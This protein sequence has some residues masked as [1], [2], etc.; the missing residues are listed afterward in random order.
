M[1]HLSFQACI[2]SGVV[3]TACGTA[4]DNV[5]LAPNRLLKHR[6]NKHPT[7]ELDARNELNRVKDIFRNAAKCL[8]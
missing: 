4:L 7:M 5:Q 6:D 8:Q 1:S 3:C 2:F